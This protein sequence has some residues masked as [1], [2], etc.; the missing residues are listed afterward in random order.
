MPPRR[1]PPPAVDDPDRLK[2]LWLP[3]GPATVLGG[4]GDGLAHVSGRVREVEVSP[5]GTRVYVATANGG[6]WY[7]SDQGSTWM[8]IGG[9]AVSPSAID[10]DYYANILVCGTISVDWDTVGENDTVYVG[11]GEITP[12]RQGYPGGSMGGIGVLRAEKPAIAA[13]D[14]QYAQVWTREGDGMTGLGIYRL[15]FNPNN[16]NQL[17]AATSNGLWIRT[18]G[19][20]GRS[21]EEGDR[22]A[23][24]QGPRGQRRDLDVEPALRRADQRQRVHVRRTA[25]TGSPRSCCPTASTDA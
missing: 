15:A 5:D 23:V 4:Q 8:P 22:H 25:P 20:G 10:V 9:W 16:K 24:R 12:R 13:R 18:P 14:D 11:T 21:V 3:L 1:D 2:D 19:G 7:S 17:A 6:V